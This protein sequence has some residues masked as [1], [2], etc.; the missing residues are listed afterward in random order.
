LLNNHKENENVVRK[1][2]KLKELNS[3]IIGL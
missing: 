3:K 1:Y 2:D